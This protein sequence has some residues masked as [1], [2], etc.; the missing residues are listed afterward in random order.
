MTKCTFYTAPA[1]A[2]CGKRAI[3]FVYDTKLGFARARCKDHRM[4][5]SLITME[6]YKLITYM[7]YEMA[8][9]LDE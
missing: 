4:N 8:R 9:M 7:E 1:Y 3:Q 5:P 6:G 2:R